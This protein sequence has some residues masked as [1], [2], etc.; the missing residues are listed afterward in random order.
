MA[1]GSLCLPPSTT[2]RQSLMDTRGRSP[3]HKRRRLGDLAAAYAH[4]MPS[5][6]P[7][8]PVDHSSQQQQP[9]SR[10]QR[11]DA[12]EDL[13]QSP[14]LHSQQQPQPQP[15]KSSEDLT[16]TAT[17]DSSIDCY[18]TCTQDETWEERW[19]RELDEE[20]SIEEDTQQYCMRSLDEEEKD[21]PHGEFTCHCK[22]LSQ[23]ERTAW[24][25][26]DISHMEKLAAVAEQEDEQAAEE[27]DESRSA[28]P[29]SPTPPSSEA[30]S[31]DAIQILKEPLD[32]G[33]PRMCCLMRKRNQAAAAEQ[34][35]QH[36]KAAEFD[37]RWIPGQPPTMSYAAHTADPEA[38]SIVVSSPRLQTVAASPIRSRSTQNVQAAVAE[39]KSQRDKDPQHQEHAL[40]V[41]DTQPDTQQ[42]TQQHTECR[43]ADVMLGSEV[44]DDTQKTWTPRS[45]S[46]S[47]P[48][49]DQDTQDS[50]M[51]WPETQGD[52]DSQDSVE[53][54]MMDL[55]D[56]CT[57]MRGF[58][59]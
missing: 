7:I 14:G 50:M 46:W 59:H 36:E 4:L 42:D 38:S 17:K 34:D 9:Q 11:Q 21:T 25:M 49:E 51:V 8:Y 24:L 40:R 57:G 16:E 30:E 29:T 58:I 22:F 35:S 20:E 48:Q 41:E 43:C 32:P 28:P 45:F 47:S 26:D 6:E 23:E 37:T 12:S 53:V 19:K 18:E 56:F 39:K 1:Q 13:T 2:P 52:Q 44:S 15:Q 33:A 10:I 54:L 55:P 5:L 31:M 3:L 27:K